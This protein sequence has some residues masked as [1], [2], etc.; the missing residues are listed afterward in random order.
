[1]G[2]VLANNYFANK[3]HGQIEAEYKFK[4]KAEFYSSMK[5]IEMVEGTLNGVFS[6]MAFTK[7]KSL[8]SLVC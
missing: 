4:L 7:E 3:Y 6:P 1:L 8:R 2:W 5:E